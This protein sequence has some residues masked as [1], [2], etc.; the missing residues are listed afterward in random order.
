[1]AVIM[2]F[3]YPGQEMQLYTTM[4]SMKY[5]YLLNIFFATPFLGIFIHGIKC[6]HVLS[7]Y[8]ANFVIQAHSKYNIQPI[9]L[10]VSQTV[11]PN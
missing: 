10:T 8:L 6:V 2:R 1:M 4:I 5:L 9:L 3:F 11:K 7:F